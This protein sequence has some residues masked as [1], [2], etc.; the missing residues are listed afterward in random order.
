MLTHLY[1]VQFKHKR[2]AGNNTTKYWA[3]PFAFIV[4][5][6]VFDI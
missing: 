6:P 1:S 5:Q 4:V 3:V 2:R